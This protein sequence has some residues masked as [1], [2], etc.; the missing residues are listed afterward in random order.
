MFGKGVPIIKLFGFQ[1]RIDASWLV[2]AVL[3]TWSLASG[4]LPYRFP[5]LPQAVYWWMGAFGALGLFASIIFHELCHSLVARR[6]GLPIRGITLFIF[7]GVA[8]MEEEPPSAKAEFFMAIAG[9]LSSILLGSICFLAYRFGVMQ[10]WP[11]AVYGV[12]SY[13]NW[14]NFILA[15]FNLVPAF[16]L[17]GGRVFRSIL[18]KWKGNL[19]WATRVSSQVG[20]GFGLLLIIL[21]LLDILTGN[22]VGGMWYFLIGMFLR[23]AAR[24]SYQR[25]LMKRALEGETV[26]R[27]MQPDPVI[28]APSVSLEEL[29]EEYIY[30]YHFKMFPVASGE[31][32]IGCV[33]TAEVKQVPRSQWRERRVSDIVIPCSAGNTLDADTDAT[34]ALSIMSRAKK[35]RMMVIDGR[36]IIGIITLKDLLKFLSL[37][38]D[39]EGDDTGKKEEA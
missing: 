3:I 8:E 21:G 31:N 15:G 29:V 22:F 2:L 38:L 28:V 4:F 26:R 1:V 6:F 10:G 11:E 36:R 18:W 7:G 5:Y 33:T 27:F 12:L 32:L 30:K 37:K 13:L 25:L 20:S 14:I 24:M 35:S 19:K 34:D 17:D 16:P 39:L 23:S 9:P